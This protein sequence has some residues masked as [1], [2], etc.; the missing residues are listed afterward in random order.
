[1]WQHPAMIKGYR[2]IRVAFIS[3]TI[4]SCGYNKG[5][6]VYARDPVTTETSFQKTTLAGNVQYYA[7][8]IQPNAMELNAM[9]CTVHNIR[10]C[11]ST[12]LYLMYRFY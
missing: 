4:Y 2:A 7:I 8:F 3:Y 6:M 11:I 12:V 5:V 1:M 10:I 9:K